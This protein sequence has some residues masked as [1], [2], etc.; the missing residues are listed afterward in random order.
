MDWGYKT[1][2]GKKLIRKSFC[3]FADVLGY[4]QLTYEKFKDK[5]DLGVF[6]RYL[7]VIDDLME[8]INE[9]QKN[10]FSDGNIFEVKIFTDNLLIAHP[11]YDRFGEAELWEVTKWLSKFQFDLA[12]EGLFTRGAITL[13]DLYVDENSVIG[14]AVIDAYKL[15]TQSAVV[16]RIILSKEISE[17]VCNEY[18][19]YY[20][21]PE[22]SPQNR[23]FV[24]DSDG[25]LFINYLIRALVYDDEEKGLPDLLIHKDRVVDGLRQHNRNPR[26]FEKY[27]W[28][29]TYHNWFCE[30][31]LK[32]NQCDE[33]CLIIDK[34]CFMRNFNKIA[35]IG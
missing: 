4:T 16:P 29:A 23:N 22:H 2:S 5:S 35:Q 34:K 11:W 32:E 17:I 15:E 24:K 7:K 6:N 12:L 1:S 8:M 13:G 26:V 14:P 27:V 20:A 25:Q 31:F 33:H 9:A 18:L 30:N 28:V 19:N 3:A 21:E 10:S